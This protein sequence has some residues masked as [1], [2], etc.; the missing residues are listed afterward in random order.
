MVSLV[1]RGDNRGT[2]LSLINEIVNLYGGSKQV[3][4]SIHKTY[5]EIILKKVRA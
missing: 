1:K 5:I 3:Q 2:G 4:S